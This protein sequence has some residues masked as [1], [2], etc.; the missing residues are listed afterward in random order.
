MS[1]E[2]IIYLEDIAD[3]MEEASD[4]W[5]HF[6]NIKTSEFLS[7]QSAHLRIAEDLESVDELAEYRDWERDMIREAIDML[8]NWDDYVELPSQYD[9]H[10]YHLMEDFT[11]ATS[12]RRKQE[13]LLAALKGNRAFRRFKD[14]LIRVGLENEWYEYRYLAFIEIAKEWCK[15]NKI[16]YK[17]KSLGPK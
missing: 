14:T 13:L 1:G 11:K 7:F 12:D 6:L 17:T 2:P 5:R 9:I 10:E 16:V 15:D 8:S 4:E 3:K